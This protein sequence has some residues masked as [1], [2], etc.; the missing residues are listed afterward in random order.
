MQSLASRKRGTPVV[1]TASGG[2]GAV[3][4]TGRCGAR[5]DSAELSPVLI[6]AIGKDPTPATPMRSPLA[7][8]LISV[9]FCFT[10]LL[11]PVTG[12]DPSP[13]PTAK[14]SSLAD[15]A[16]A[17]RGDE[18]TP[19]Q[20]Q[21]VAKGLAWLAQQQGEDGGYGGSPYASQDSHHAGITALAALAFMQ[22]GNLPGRGRYGVQVQHCL[23]FVMNNCQESGLIASDT[24]NGAMYGHGFATLFLGEIY[25]MTGDEAVKE[26]LVKAVHLI[27]RTQ[28]AEGGWRYQPVPYD[29]DISVTICQVMA[30]RAARDAGIK[31][32]KSVVD[33]AIKYVRAC[34]NDDGGFCY[35]AEMHGAGSGYAR[36][37]AGVAALYYA[38]VFDGDEIERGLRYLA[39]FTPG[40]GE[41]AAEGMYFYGNYYAVQAMFL[42]GGE[43]WAQFYP[44]I[45]DQI[46]ERQDKTAGSWSGEAGDS[47]ATAMALIILQMLNR[48]LPVYSGKGPGD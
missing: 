11:V 20:K 40:S 1:L 36:T 15:H 16:N 10:G 38:G 17:V 25:G 31:V 24:S 34:Q 29:A 45:R 5:V 30:L 48:Y 3:D 8:A 35:Q 42:A 12:A 7:A 32:E 9:S 26:R 14:T 19:A 43:Y 33:K 13:P 22:S 2:W 46:I 21:S 4:R 6:A 37:A 28:N 44:A 23:D 47:Y 18:I 27:E 39:R 41:Q